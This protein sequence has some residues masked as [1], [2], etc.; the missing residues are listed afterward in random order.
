MKKNKHYRKDVILAR[1]I[2]AASLILVIVLLCSGIS[3]LFKS[4]G[5]DKDSQKPQDT[6]PPVSESQNP[7]SESEDENTP[8]TEEQNTEDQNTENQDTEDDTDVNED[9]SYEPDV[10]K[11]TYLKTT[12]QLRFRAEPNTKCDTLA[13]LDAGEKLE[14]IE[15]VNSYWYKAVYNG[16]EGYVNSA[17]VEVIEE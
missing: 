8:S 3:L 16:Q 12:G 4:S 11:K 13:Y 14:L 10:E 1:V 15:K 9:T 6:K 2:A 17:Y 7:G 5:S